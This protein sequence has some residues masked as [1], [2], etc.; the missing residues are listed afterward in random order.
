MYRWRGVTIA[1][2]LMGSTLLSGIPAEA[3][4]ETTTETTP[5]VGAEAVGKSTGQASKEGRAPKQ[6]RS[7]AK[8]HVED[9]TAGKSQPKAEDSREGTPGTTLMF[10]S[11]GKGNSGET[12]K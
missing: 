1:M 3:A 7:S 11:D 12:D 5:K 4:Q 9:S 8:G 2:M 10:R 6:R